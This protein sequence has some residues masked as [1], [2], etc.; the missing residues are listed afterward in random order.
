[1]N[2]WGLIGI[3]LLMSLIAVFS[4]GFQA[5]PDNGFSPAVKDT[6]KK[7]P[8]TIDK[9][10]GKMPLAFIPNKGQMD[11]QVYFYLQ[12]K[13]KSVYFTSTGL[14]YTLAGPTGSRPARRWTTPTSS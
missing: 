1:M 5:Q 9:D 6:G 7:A 14:T 2:K 11:K 12:G 13:D 8:V 4:A 10:Y 3:F